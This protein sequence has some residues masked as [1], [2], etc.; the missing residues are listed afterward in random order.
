MVNHSYYM[1]LAL[2]EAEA[3]LSKGE[4]PIGAVVV[5][6]GEVVGCGHNL[7]ETT[8]DPTA[9]AEMIALRMAS[10]KLGRWR[11]T[12]ADI[13]ATLEPCSMCAGAISLAR[14]DRLIFGAADFKAGACGSI[15]NIVGDARLNHRPEIISGTLEEECQSIVREFFKER[16]HQTG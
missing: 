11:L 1:R 16:R 13:Y 7:R 10:E 8:K 5:A 3:A 15:F 2:N 9:H 4:V 6:G 12:G 14:V